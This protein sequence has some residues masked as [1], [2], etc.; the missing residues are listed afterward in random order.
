MIE[1]AHVNLIGV[2]EY[3]HNHGLQ[4]EDYLI[5]EDTNQFMWDYWCD[6]WDNQEEIER[7]YQKMIDLRNWLMSH[8]NEYSIDTHY[9][10]MYGKNG[11]KCCNSILK[12]V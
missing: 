5:V 9:Q 11:S 4:S 3:F 10:D 8:L 6:N 7:G 12:R 2:L 1:D